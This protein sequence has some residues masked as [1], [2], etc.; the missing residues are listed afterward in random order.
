ML[1]TRRDGHAAEIDGQGTGSRLYVCWQDPDSRE[2]RPVGVLSSWPSPGGGERYDF[3]YVEG[4][5][6][7]PFVPFSSSPSWSGRTRPTRSSPCSRTA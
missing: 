1:S 3:R 6:Q 7:T 4:A 2:I 5:R